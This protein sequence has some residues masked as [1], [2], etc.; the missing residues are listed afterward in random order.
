M[1]DDGGREAGGKLSGLAAAVEGLASHS[2]GKSVPMP[3]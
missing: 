3:I 1:C 2:K